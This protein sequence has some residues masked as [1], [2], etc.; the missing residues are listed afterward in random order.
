MEK[1]R[2]ISELVLLEENFEERERKETE[3]SGRV[4]RAKRGARE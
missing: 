3:G 2:V 4:R 1:E